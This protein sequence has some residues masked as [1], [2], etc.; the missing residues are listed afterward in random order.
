MKMNS[1][2]SYILFSRN[3]NVSANIDDNTIISENKNKLLGI[4]LDSNLCFEDHVNNLCKK[5]SQK[6]SALAIIDPYMCLG[7]RRTVNIC[8][9]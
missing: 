6:L 9:I 1:G 5:A 2:K 3:D 8:N 4:I 7:K